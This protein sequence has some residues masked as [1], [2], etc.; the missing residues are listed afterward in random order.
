MYDQLLPKTLVLCFLLVEVQSPMWQGWT[1]SLVRCSSWL[2]L[3]SVPSGL[4]FVLKVGRQFVVA[5]GAGQIHWARFGLDTATGDVLYTINPGVG[6]Y[7]CLSYE[8]ETGAVLCGGENGNVAA[9]NPSSGEVKY[10]TNAS[11][12]E[13]W[14]IVPAVNAGV[15]LCGGGWTGLVSGL[16]SHTGEVLYTV[17]ATIGKIFSMIYVEELG[18][19][20]CGGDQGKIAGLDPKTGTVSFVTETHINED[21]TLGETWSLA[22]VP[23]TGLVYAAGNNATIMV[24]SV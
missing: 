16:H 3:A 21:V 9:I 19:A 10:T 13:V 24:L 12:G 8:P 7:V 1:L 20:I 4:L 23:G 18:V 15:V 5:V 11:V 6:K 2:I 17:N 14:S 22:H